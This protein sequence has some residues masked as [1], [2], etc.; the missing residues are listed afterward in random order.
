MIYETSLSSSDVFYLVFSFD[1]SQHQRQA[2][3]GCI[4]HYQGWIAGWLTWVSAKVEFQCYDSPRG[5]MQFMPSRRSKRALNPWLAMNF[6]RDLSKFITTRA[7][8]AESGRAAIRSCR[9]RGA[10]R[11]N[12]HAEPFY[13][14]TNV[15]P[16]GAELSQA[17]KPD[18]E[19]TFVGKF[20][21]AGQGLNQQF[22]LITLLSYELKGLWHEW[23]MSAIYEGI[24]GYQTA[25]KCGTLWIM[26]LSRSC[27]ERFNYSMTGVCC[28]LYKII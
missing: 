13:P 2:T 23:S 4:G 19:L 17:R 6:Q 15:Y 21:N 24:S 3:R 5:K 1:L 16:L 14:Y 8:R 28:Y 22:S 26:D 18:E 20:I 10:A 27:V 25:C 11:L 9:G 12:Y 7:H